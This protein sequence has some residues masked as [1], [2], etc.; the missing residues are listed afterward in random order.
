MEEI[1]KPIS[2]LGLGAARQACVQIVGADGAH[3]GS[4]LGV[5]IGGET[6]V[7]TC[8]HVIAG[9]ALDAIGVKFISSAG[10]AVEVAC[11]IDD[12][13]SSPANDL[14]VLRAGQDVP[15]SI[16][17]VLARVNSKEYAGGLRCIALTH[18]DPDSLTALL[19][20]AG[21]I[22]YG[23]A[24]EGDP[25]TRYAVPTAYRLSTASDVRLGTSGAPVLC[26]GQVVGLVTSRRKGAPDTE[27]ELYL[28]PLSAWAERLEPLQEMIVPFVDEALRSA[29]WVGSPSD[30]PFSG[31]LPL[32]K[33]DPDVYLN[34]GADQ[35]AREQLAETGA[36]I[37]VG[38]PKSGKSRLVSELLATRPDDLVI[39]PFSDIPPPDFEGSSLR[40]RDVF[41]LLDDVHDRAET[42]R[43][44][45]W[46]ERLRAASQRPIRIVATSRDA[47]DWTR[48]INHQGPL[49]RVTGGAE[50]AIR[51]SMSDGRGEDLTPEEGMRLANLDFSV[52]G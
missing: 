41:L 13:L 18:L 43:P 26:E 32:D 35:L 42:L 3:I 51:T 38:K 9:S 17:P 37:I 10:D 12:D 5:E 14:A 15:S 4:G 52:R 36:V 31:V 47:A 44:T 30:V 11:T 16:P 28:M 48:V 33:Y 45:Q 22:R 50:A 49:L 8:H 39:A 23:G 1:R 34:R 6:Y 7:L 29:A 19:D 24:T 27:R 21:P 40:G 20:P 46:I 25:G 2:S